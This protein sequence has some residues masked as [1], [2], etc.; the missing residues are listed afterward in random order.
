MEQFLRGSLADMAQPDLITWAIPVF[1]LL[2]VLEGVVLTREAR[3]DAIDRLAE[4]RAA[5]GRPLKGYALK[6]TI[7][8]LTMG[9]GSQI[10]LALTTLVGLGGYVV[11]WNLTP[12]DL[13]TGWV[14]WTVAILGKDFVYYWFH[15]GLARDAAA[16]GRPRRAPLQRALQ[17]LHGAAPGLDAADR[18][19]RSA[20]SLSCSASTRR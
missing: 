10:V 12:L 11:L 18:A 14:A 13:G 4:E 19:G 2:M 15:R 8:S 5:A 6:D 3:E 20:P 17:P 7:T 1:F 16:L 9:L